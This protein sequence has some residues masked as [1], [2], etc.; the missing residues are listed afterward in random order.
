MP[1][2]KTKQVKRNKW[3]GEKE[4]CYFRDDWKTSLIRWPWT[5]T[6]VPGW[7]SEKDK[8][9]EMECEVIDLCWGWGPTVY[10][11]RREST[12]NFL[13]S[14]R[15][16]TR[17]LKDHFGFCL[18]IWPGGLEGRRGWRGMARQRSLFGDN[19]MSYGKRRQW[20]TLKW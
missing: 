4:L 20:I 9:P 7:G 13:N 1:K 12:G 18:E 3:E 10:S 17:H 11:V 15:T 16:Q 8:S 19:C 2:R 14:N 6:R 5:G